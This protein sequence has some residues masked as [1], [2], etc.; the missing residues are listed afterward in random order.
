MAELTNFERQGLLA[1]EELEKYQNSGDVKPVDKAPHPFKRWYDSFRPRKHDTSSQRRHVEGWSDSSSHGSRDHRSSVSE[2]SQFETMLTASTRVTSQCLLQS[3]T[4]VPGRT[5]ASM[6]SDSGNS[7]DSPHSS[8]S[9][10]LDEATDLRATKR[11]HIL[12]EL[13]TTECDYVLGLKALTGILTI[14]N[15]RRKIS[16]NV[17]EILNMHEH[18][19]TKLQAASPMSALH[20]QRAS[21]LEFTSKGISKRLSTNLGSLRGLQQRSLRSRTMKASVNQRLKALTAD[22]AEA[23]DVA[24]KIEELSRLF[25]A[26]DEYCANYEIFSHD[27]ALL[28]R[29]PAEWTIY[30]RGI[31][32]MAKSVASTERRRHDDSKSM[33]FNDLL[34]K[35]IQRLCKYPLMLQDLLRAT[36]VSD[37][38]SAH[39]E[40]QQILDSTRKLVG[41]INMATG[42]PVYKDRISKTML[43]REKVDVP[44]SVSDSNPMAIM[45]MADVLQN[46]S[47][48]DIYQDLGAMILC[49]VLHVTYQTTEAT[50]TG[51]FMVCALFNRYMLFAKGVDDLRRLEAVS[52][53]CLDKVKIDGLCCYGCIFSWKLLFQDRNRNYEFVLSASSAAEERH[54]NTEILRLSASLAEVATPGTGE[55]EAHSF[56]TLRLAPLDQVQYQVSSL[57]R[58]SCMDSAAVTCK[59]GVQHVVIRKTHYPRHVEE[60]TAQVEGEIERPKTPP[61][62]ASV[63]LVARRI[64]RIRLERLIADIWSRDLLPTPGMVLGRGDL[65]RRRPLMKNLNIHTGFHR[66]SASV[67][68]TTSRKPSSE[69]RSEYDGETKEIGRSSDVYDD[70]EDKE[71]ECQPYSPVTPQQTRNLRLMGS[72]RTNSPRGEIRSSQDDSP[73][74]APSPK[75]WSSP[76]SLFSALAPKKLKKAPLSG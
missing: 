17:Q 45:N 31:E 70:K 15:I 11:R 44:K 23:L 69:V 26:Y 62:G 33:T 13:V 35:P 38:P 22:P 21:D 34:I 28:R 24:R 55:S 65:F 8:S 27:V 64:D 5:T 66:R 4:S 48:Q 60:P 49:G 67:G 25:S 9:N 71:V 75:K 74:P 42:N 30:D 29:K 2:S 18:F 10:H 58:R 56:L 50:T 7:G 39:D 68:V 16:D 72:P 54:W 51:E 43:L 63:T 53:V 76:K 19:L 14:F 61:E 36:P 41:R 3:R 47:L 32:A 12:R 1:D 46:D 52:C 6:F 20:A 59:Y 57:A 37:C 73:E 40:M